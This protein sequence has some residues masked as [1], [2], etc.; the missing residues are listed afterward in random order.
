MSGLPSP[1]ID[2]LLGLTDQTLSPA[3]LLVTE[4]DG[5]A[6]WGGDVESYGIKGLQK[7]MDVSEYISFLAGML[8]L[9]T[10]SIFLPNIQTKE[11]IFAD[12]YLFNREQ[13]TWILLLDATAKTV[14]RL[15]MQQK[16]YDSRLQMTD[17]EREGD[18]LYKANVV[19]E[20]LVRERTVDLMQTI[21]QLQQELAERKRVEKERRQG[22]SQTP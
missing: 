18:A 5:L 21:L 3:Y 4:K 10:S 16:L 8:P 22:R 14:G 17:L 20:E 19:L 12:V 13:G 6:E 9:G 15:N 11:G 2:F 7:N 1:I